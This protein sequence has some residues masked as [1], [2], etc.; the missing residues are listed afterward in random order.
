MRSPREIAFRLR[1]EGGNLFRLVQP[2]HTSRGA[3]SPLAGLP[4]PTVVA[5]GL[6]GTPYAAQVIRLAEGILA[7]RFPLMGCVI[8][9]GPHIDWRRDYSS[10]R[11]SGVDYFRWMPYLNFASVG[12][13]KVVWE[14]NRHQHLVLLAQAWRLSRR[15]EFLREIEAQLE[16]WWGA[17]P[18]GY[19][20][21]WASALEVAFRSLSWIWIFHLAGGAIS[22]TVRRRL[23]DSLYAHARHI[24][25]NLS[26]YFSPNTHLMGEAV[27]LH[28]IGVLF[29]EF[30]YAPRWR[31]AAGDMVRA[32]MRTQVQADGSHFEHS[33]YYHGYAFDM[34][35][36]SAVIEP[37]PP[38]YL[39]GLAR[40]G[41][42]LDALLGPQRSLP[43]FGD[44][45]GGRL[46]HPYGPRDRFG[47]ASL[48]AFSGNVASSFVASPPVPPNTA[49]HSVFVAPP[50]PSNTAADSVLVRPPVW[51]PVLPNAAA[52]SVF[53]AP[54]IPPNPAGDYA[55]IGA[56]WLAGRALGP[57]PARRGSRFFE[58]SGIAVMESGNVHLVADA[59]PFG[60][61][62]AGHSH[63]DTLS[64]VLRRG[65]EYLLIDAG[66][67]TYVASAQWRNWFRGSAAHNTVRIDRLDQATPEG[68]FRWMDRPD[69]QKVAW[70][71]SPACDFL[72]AICRYRGCEHLRRIQFVKPSLILIVDEITGPPGEHLIEQFWHSGESVT[73]DSPRRFRVGRGARLLL[74]HGSEL[75]TGGENGWQSRA[76]GSKEP[77]AVVRVER[78]GAFPMQ[79][80]AAIDLD[81]NASPEM[82]SA[83]FQQLGVEPGGAFG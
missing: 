17:N 22:E 42:Y 1:Q 13:H 47:C 64:F 39:A 78:H 55:E 68:P 30:P 61:G 4:D 38:D 46:Y 51:P 60:I 52:D 3:K 58:N 37:M 23:L 35:M 50:V 49:A 71:S 29:P 19:G 76:M 15:Q 26:V 59:G 24:A 28:A 79:L 75:S 8:E 44:D 45:D 31:R 53:V 83:A 66:T 12:D 36:F 77:A 48:A 41:E 56:W 33:S 74:S 5:A 21:N 40:M 80:L 25:G 69:V 16:S 11:S 81:G 54:P 32:Q 2:P 10:G 14:L 20:I 57:A 62:R 43:F 27:A 70:N 7:H 67:Y 6:A 82:I 18:Y 63:S 73:G 9:T 65:E 72:A 34:L